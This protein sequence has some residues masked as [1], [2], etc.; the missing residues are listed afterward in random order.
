[1]CVQAEE[2]LDVLFLVSREQNDSER[3]FT[4]SKSIGQRAHHI[5]QEKVAEIDRA[6]WYLSQAYLVCVSQ[7]PIARVY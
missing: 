7:S 4:Y 3:K 1:M 2:Q 5:T 6:E